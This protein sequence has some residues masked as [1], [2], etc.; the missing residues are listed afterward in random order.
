MPPAADVAAVLAVHRQ[1]WDRDR[2]AVVCVADGRQDCPCHRNAA[3]LYD[4]EAGP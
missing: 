4:H 3:D 2:R 1:V